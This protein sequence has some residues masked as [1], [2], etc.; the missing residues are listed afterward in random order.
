MEHQSAGKNWSLIDGKMFN[1]LSRSTQY[2]LRS[3][4][5]TA[6]PWFLD[7]WLIF[8]NFVWYEYSISNIGYFRSLL[9]YPSGGV[10]SWSKTTK[11]KSNRKINWNRYHGHLMPVGYIQIK[12]S[13]S[14]R[15][16]LSQCIAWIYFITKLF[17]IL[18]ATGRYL[19]NWSGSAVKVSKYTFSFSTQ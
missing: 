12:N 11:F 10:L 2:L 16:K 6:Q 3:C 19:L 7:E 4:V 18:S 5:A 14:L 1:F 17:R 15:H 13:A 9:F 8:Y